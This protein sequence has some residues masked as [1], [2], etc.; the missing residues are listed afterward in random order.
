M[1]NPQPEWQPTACNLCSLNCG[2]EIQVEEGRFK[3][4]RGD[5][6]QNIEE[7]ITTY[8]Q[9]L[10]VFTRETMPVEWATTIEPLNRQALWLKIIWD[11]EPAPVGGIAN[12]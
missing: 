10:Q 8:K 4:I 6:A 3:R 2:V 7:A 12:V 1:A 9:S 11:S 5:R